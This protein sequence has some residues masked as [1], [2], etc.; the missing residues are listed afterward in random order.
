MD[1]NNL[2]AVRD[3][4]IRMKEQKINQAIAENERETI[5]PKFAEYDETYNSAIT[6]IDNEKRKSYQIADEKY[7]RDINSAQTMLS[8]KKEKL[9]ND[10]DTKIRARISIENDS[11]INELN[12]IIDKF[13]G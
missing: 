11:Y 12:K 1:V 9:K 6:A 3:E 13:G 7:N 4:A 5:L 8:S 2:I 10:E